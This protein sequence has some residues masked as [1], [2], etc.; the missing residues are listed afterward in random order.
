MH[1]ASGLLGRPVRRLRF[2][3]LEDTELYDGIWCSA[4]LLHVPEKELAAV[5]ARLVRSLKLGGIWYMSFKLGRG[6]RAKDGRLFTDQ[7]ETSL[8]GLLGGL[9][10][11]E[12]VELWCTS[13][14]RPMRSHE[15]WLN[16]LTRKSK[17]A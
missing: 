14:R 2:E 1:Q 13:D 15:Q 3:E 9:P 10:K 6:Q 17:L 5:F 4:S 8:S 12:L 11:L 16:A 7:D